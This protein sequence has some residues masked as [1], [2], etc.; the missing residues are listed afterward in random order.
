M[1]AS[2]VQSNWRFYVENIHDFGIQQPAIFFIKNCMNERTYALGSRIAS[3]VLQTHLPHSFKHITE[4]QR[5]I[6][7]IQS[8]CSNA[9]DLHTEVTLADSWNI[10]SAF[11]VISSDKTK[12]IEL[13]CNQDAAIAAQPEAG[14]YAVGHIELKFKLNEIK[15]LKITKLESNWLKEIIQ[16]AECFAFLMPNVMFI[17]HKE[18]IVKI[19]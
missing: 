5:I 19:K 3:S 10:P 15:P 11:N 16:G 9:P 1:F 12:L 4:E 13:I 8:G 17:S 2:P 18:K 6:T 7:E 14:V